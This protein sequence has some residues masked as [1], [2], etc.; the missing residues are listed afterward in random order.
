MGGR[1]LPFNG[2]VLPGRSL[3]FS[4]NHSKIPDRYVWADLPRGGLGNKLFVW[5]NAYVVAERNQVPLVVTGWNNPFGFRT[6]LKGG[7]IRRYGALFRNSGVKRS[8]FREWEKS[9]QETLEEPALETHLKIGSRAL[10]SKLPPWQDW[11]QPLIPYRSM[12]VQGFHAMLSER[13]KAETSG[14]IGSPIAIHVRLGDFRRVG[15]HEDFAKV[16]NART[17]MG[18]FC[19]LVERIR[20]TIGW[21]APVRIYSDGRNSELQDLLRMRNVTRAKDRNPVLDMVE[22]SLSKVLILSAGSSFS[23]WAAFLGTQP[24]IAH[25]EHFHHRIREPSTTV[26][27]G[28]ANPYEGEWDPLL[29]RNLVEGLQR[30]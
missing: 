26:F 22:M 15:V 3:D 30:A 20:D 2:I 10:F 9:I 21:D 25:F 14:L 27:E 29:I 16:G 12:V 28:I 4:M 13:V 5:G 19:R 17:P 7:G 6:F 11:F 23:Q 24:V 8:R 1:D 18:Y